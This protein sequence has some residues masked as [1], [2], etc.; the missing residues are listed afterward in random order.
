[1]E[2]KRSSKFD[3][4]RSGECESCFSSRFE[5]CSLGLQMT[6][7]LKRDKLKPPLLQPSMLLQS[8]ASETSF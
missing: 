8:S 3:I 5:T 6:I 2:F 1:M 7:A 4:K